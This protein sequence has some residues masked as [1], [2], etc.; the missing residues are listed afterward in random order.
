MIGEIQDDGQFEVVWKTPEPLRAQPWS[1]FI[2]GNE[3]KP[4]HA[5]KSN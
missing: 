2:P 1:P 5:L 4:E 3:K